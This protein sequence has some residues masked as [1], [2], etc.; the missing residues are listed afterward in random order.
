MIWRT[1]VLDTFVTSPISDDYL[2]KIRHDL[3]V[4]DSASFTAVLRFCYIFEMVREAK[5]NKNPG[6]LIF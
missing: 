4:V 1:F 2:N 5:K 6:G 3:D